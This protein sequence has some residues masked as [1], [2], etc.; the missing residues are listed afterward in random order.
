MAAFT[1]AVRTPAFRVLV[2][3]AVEKPVKHMIR[4][5]ESRKFLAINYLKK[6]ASAQYNAKAILYLRVLCPN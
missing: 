2:F 4:K 3:C 1:P 5:K 6:I